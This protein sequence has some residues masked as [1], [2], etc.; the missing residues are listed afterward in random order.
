MID[1]EQAHDKKFYE[2]NYR[3]RI[4]KET[5]SIIYER[6]SQCSRNASGHGFFYKLISET[7]VTIQLSLPTS[8]KSKTN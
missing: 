5:K 7:I 3:Y 1:N 8:T 6:E 4:I 2:Q